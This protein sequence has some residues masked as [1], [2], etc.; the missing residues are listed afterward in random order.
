MSLMY[1]FWNASDVACLS[2]LARATL[3]LGLP[4]MP[5]CRALPRAKHQDDE[6]NDAEQDDET[7][8]GGRHGS[9][10]G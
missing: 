2:L 10:R 1:A 9:A 4:E 7:D 8:I 5:S 6:G 3:L